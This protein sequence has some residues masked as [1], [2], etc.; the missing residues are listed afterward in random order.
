M[1]AAI[2]YQNDVRSTVRRCAGSGE[3]KVK[4]KKA[5]EI[6]PRRIVT[7]TAVRAT[8]TPTAPRSVG[9]R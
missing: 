8:T 1:A 9:S 6:P 3:S 5:L 2:V 7:S 4:R